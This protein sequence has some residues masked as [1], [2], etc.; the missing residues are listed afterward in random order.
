M[1]GVQTCALPIS[2]DTQR[3][4]L[5]YAVSNKSRKIAKLLIDAGADVNLADSL[6]VTPLMMAGL[7]KEKV[8]RGV[9][10]M[11]VGCVGCG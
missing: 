8:V 7:N 9:C 6:G 4:P 5:F 11:C 2:V 1:T 3:T 10:G